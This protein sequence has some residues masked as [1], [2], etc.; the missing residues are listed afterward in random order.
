MALLRVAARAHPERV[1]LVDD[2][3]RLRYGE[4]WRRAEVTAVALHEG[5]GGQAGQRVAIACRN[6]AAA[7][8]A[9]IAGSRL[10]AHVYLVNPELSGDQLR[11]LDARLRLF[12][13]RVS[14]ISGPASRAHDRGARHAFPVAP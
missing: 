12:L 9:I 6:H 10:G 4:L 7:I 8:T 14:C 3:E 2:R 5:Y 13:R 1:A 11:A